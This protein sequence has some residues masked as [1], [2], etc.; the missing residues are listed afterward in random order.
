MSCNSKTAGC[1]VKC[2]EVWYS[3]D[4]CSTYMGLR[5]PCS[6][7]GHFGGDSV[8]L[9]Q[10]WYQATYV[11]NLQVFFVLLLPRRVPRSL[12]LLYKIFNF[13]IYMSLPLSFFNTGAQNVYNR[14]SCK[15]LR[16][17]NRQANTAGARIWRTLL[18]VISTSI[19][20]IKFCVICVFD[21]VW[22]LISSV[23][24]CQQSYFRDAGVRRPSVSPSSVVR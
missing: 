17:W 6:F 2:I 16:L 8:H 12:D 19:Q 21:F 1:R 4:A 14:G 23:W 22:F 13:W 11:Q 10:A 7:Q 20:I 15:R 9:S 24:F 3:G 18:A 5:W